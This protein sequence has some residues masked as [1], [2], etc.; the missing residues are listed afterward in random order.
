MRCTVR[1]R[2]HESATVTELRGKVFPG[3]MV[4]VDSALA[5]KYSGP[6]RYPTD[7]DRSLFWRLTRPLTLF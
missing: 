5:G 1:A 4:I 3:M 2:I 7:V 6:S